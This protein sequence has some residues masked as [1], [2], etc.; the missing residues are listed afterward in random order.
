KRHERRAP[1]MGAPAK[2]RS[3]H[4]NSLA[5]FQGECHLFITAMRKAMTILSFREANSRRVWA[6]FGLALFLF[7][8]LL[9][10]SPLL[11]KLVHSDANSTS[12][13]CGVTMLLRGHV[14]PAEALAPLVAF[15]ATLFFLLPLFQSAVFSS[16]DYRF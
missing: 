2:S 8:Q 5:G 14:S 3:C 12:H 16:F 6:V 9:T 10:S 7:L 1:E 13:Q 11:H 4:K 15:V